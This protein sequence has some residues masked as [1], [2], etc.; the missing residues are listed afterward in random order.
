MALSCAHRYEV[1]STHAQSKALFGSPS[2][3]W[4][5]CLFVCFGNT[6]ATSTEIVLIFLMAIPVLTL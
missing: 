5:V 1:C 2:H 6:V 3:H 4:G